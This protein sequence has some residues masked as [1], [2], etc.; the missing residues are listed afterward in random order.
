VYQVLER[1]GGR[2]PA[3]SMALAGS[4]RRQALTSL[5]STDA[6]GSSIRSWASTLHAA[7]SAGGE[8][9]RRCL[10]RTGQQIDDLV[11]DLRAAKDGGYEWV[12][13]AVLPD[14]TLRK[15]PA[16]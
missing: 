11:S 2:R 7:N 4:A 10:A 14:L 1:A 16:V 6:S 13:I 3:L 5:R 9:T 12:P 8:G 15:P